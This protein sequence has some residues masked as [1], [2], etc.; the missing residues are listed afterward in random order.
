MFFIKKKVFFSYIHVQKIRPEVPVNIHK[1]KETK[2]MNETKRKNLSTNIKTAVAVFVTTLAMAPTVF[3]A[4]MDA[5]AASTMKNL[6][7]KILPY[8]AVIG[9]PVALMGGFKLIMAFRNDQGDAVPAAARDLAIGIVLIAFG[10]LG[11]T[12]LD[13]IM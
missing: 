2:T 10:G 3:A 7:G 6:V 5:G 4:D 1:E 11:K 8:I 13:A 12:L 9:I